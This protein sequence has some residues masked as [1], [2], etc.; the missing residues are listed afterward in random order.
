MNRHIDSH[1]I[2]DDAGAVLSR[3]ADRLAEL[4]DSSF[5]GKPSGRYRIPMKLLRQMMMRRRLYEADIA[6]LSRAMTERGYVLIDMDSF[7]VILSAHTFANY[8]RANEDSIA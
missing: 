6:A 7:V 2:P 8:R 4:Y 3:C 5:G 1:M